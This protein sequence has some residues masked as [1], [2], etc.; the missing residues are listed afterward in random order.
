MINTYD[1][2]PLSNVCSPSLAGSHGVCPLAIISTIPDIARHMANLI[3]RAE[4]EVILATNY[5]MHS[6][7]SEIITNALRELSR[8]AV[9][10]G[11]HIVVKVIYDRGSIKQVSDPCICE[12]CLT[13]LLGHQQSSAGA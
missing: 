6:E 1:Y 8:R 3:V 5:W 10:G 12:V 11:R 4:H 13:F 9:E 2:D 7:P